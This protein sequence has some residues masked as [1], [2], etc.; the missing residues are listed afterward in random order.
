[1][2]VQKVTWALKELGLEYERHNVGGSFGGT[3]T[4]SYLKMNPNRVVPT[5][6]DGDV[7]AWESNSIVRY[8]AR[9]LAGAEALTGALATGKVAH[10]E[11]EGA[12]VGDCEAARSSHGSRRSRLHLLGSRSA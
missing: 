2:N 9:V 1:M 10:K 5:L 7:T 3:D 6:Q 4:D 11:R 12:S 8:L